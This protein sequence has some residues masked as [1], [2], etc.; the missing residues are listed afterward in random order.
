MMNNKLSLFQLC[1]STFPNGSF[2][3]SFGLET[4]I[5]KDIVHDAESFLSWLKVYVHEQLAY[6]DGLAVKLI[7]EALEKEDY[8]QLWEIDHLLKVQN[9]ARESR[10][11]TQRMGESML[12]IA[13]SVYGF[14]H[15]TT[16]RERI[17]NKQSFGH[18]AVVFTIAGH[19]LKVEKETTILYYLYSTIVGLIQNAVR[20]IPLGQTVGQKMVYEFQKDLK[21]VTEKIMSLDEAEFGVVSPGLELGQMQHE[22]VNIR[23]FSS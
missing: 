17:R 16:Y 15:L 14:E 21:Q 5:Q 7:Y 20:A 6:A 3:Q 13:E 11:G 8:N 18:P 12:N 22:R 4:Y 10:E 19:E 23:I 9:L 2:S 1:D